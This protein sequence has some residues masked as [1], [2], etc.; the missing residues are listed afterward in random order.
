MRSPELEPSTDDRKKVLNA[1]PKFQELSDGA[2]RI[3]KEIEN[4]ISTTASPSLSTTQ[5]PVKAE[6]HAGYIKYT[7][8]I[9]DGQ[10]V[11]LR[12]E[13]KIGDVSNTPCSFDCY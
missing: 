12:K 2:K 11:E 3:C 4:M 6:S 7:G 8:D 1:M 5:S 13:M 9:L 10:M